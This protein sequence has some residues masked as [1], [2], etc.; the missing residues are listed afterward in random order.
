M[1]TNKLTRRGF[2]RRATLGAGCAVS[3][4]LM[5][6]GSSLGADAKTA[7][8]SRINLACIGV[9]GQ[10]SGNL[11][12][13][14]SDERVQVVAICDVDDSHRNQALQAAKLKADA[15]YK[16]F[17]ELLARSDVDAVMIATPDHWHSLVTAAACRAG[18]D[19]YCEKP[20]AASI[21]EGRFVCDL[22]RKHK[23]VLQ[24]GTWRRS[25]VYTRMACEWVRNGYLGELKEIE[26][27]VPASFFI[28]GGYTG[29]E[30]PQPVPK[31]FDY[32]MWQG[33]APEAP[34]TPARCHFNFRWIQD[35]APGYITDWGAH[36][37]DVAQWGNNTDDT[38]PVAVKASDVRCREKGIYDAPEGYRIEYRYA[39][40][41]RMT[42]V[43]T[44]DSATHGTKFIGTKGWVF[45]ENSRLVT[46]PASLRRTKIKAGETHLYTSLNHHRN[47]IDC[48][49]SRGPTA[50][51]AE[52]AHRA[53]TCCHMGAIAARLKRPL[54]FDP[55]TETF[56]SDA[57]ANALLMRTMR[58]PWR[59]EP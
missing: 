35:Y 1:R 38:A 4:P 44:P 31:G 53:A 34:Y 22:V 12:A 20:L 10:G 36:F 2:L 49:I 26:V 57:Q 54:E 41:V 32:A 59:L 17:R 7:P 40:G 25:G 39:N 14:L 30:G 23:R 3:L 55:K 29:L 28:T 45:T 6:P 52:A 16:D 13:F 58:G 46:E 33:P 43:A 48:V 8:N 51:P 21:G 19:I 15:G 56:V 50:A 47:F 42:M 37:I 27:G 9:G 24:T 18:K 5:V 11:G